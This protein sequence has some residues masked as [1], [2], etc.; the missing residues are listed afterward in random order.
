MKPKFTYCPFC[1]QELQK[2]FI[3]GKERQH[4]PACRFVDYKNP[5]PVTVAI[6]VRD[7]R[8]L[9]IK[10]GLPPRKGSWGFPSGFIEEGESAEEAC[11]R[12]LKEETGLS[13]S[14]V[15]LV[16][17]RRVED[18]EIYGDMLVVLY[19][20]RVDEGEPEPGDEVED[21][22]FVEKSELP[23]LYRKSYPELIEQVDSG[24]I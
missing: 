19:L 20:V 24:K 18:T 16:R 17:V 11:L 13:G 7:R 4:C 12:E 10:R 1:G 23:E 15:E 2:G 14:V 6:A 22:R 8:F 21:A 5:L 9:L 3:D